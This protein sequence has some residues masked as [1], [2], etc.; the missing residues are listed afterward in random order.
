MATPSSPSEPDADDAVDADHYLAVPV[1]P[2]WLSCARNASCADRADIIKGYTTHN[3]THQKV[4]LIFSADHTPMEQIMAFYA[5]HVQCSI[6]AFGAGHLY[7]WSATARVGLFWPF[8]TQHRESADAAMLKYCARSWTFE[9]AP[10]S[11]RAIQI[12]QLRSDKGSKFVPFDLDTGLPEELDSARRDAPAALNALVS[13]QVRPDEDVK[14]V[15]FHFDTGLPPKLDAAHRDARRFE[16]LFSLCVLDEAHH[17]KN[18]NS[19]RAIAIR[20]LTCRLVIA[21]ASSMTDSVRDWYGI[22]RFVWPKV[23]KP[24]NLLSRHRFHY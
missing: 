10:A 8:N 3:G 24:S 9:L 12:K 17:L 4:Q 1:L 15:A 5:S 16:E 20:K 18:P 7:H 21:T 23:Q 19:R 13:K 2:V 14:F 22:L 6:S 11:S